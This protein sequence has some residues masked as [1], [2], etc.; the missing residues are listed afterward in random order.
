MVS[1]PLP[2]GIDDFEKVICG[3]YYYVD[4][5]NF[6]KELLDMKGEVNLFTRPR[7]FGKTLGISTV[8]YFF[9]DTGSSVENKKRQAL[10]DGMQIMQHGDRYTQE[11]NRYPVITLALKSS[12]QP[13]WDLAYGCLKEEIGREYLRHSE[14]LDH[15][16]TDE[17]Q[18]RFNDIMNLRGSQ[19]DFVTSIRFLSDCLYQYYKKK[20]IILIDEYD[21]PLENAYFSGFYAEMIDFLRSIFESSLKTNPSL[22]FAVLTGCLRISKESIFTGLNNPKMISILSEAYGEHFGFL[23]SEVDDMLDFYQLSEAK[24]LVKEWYDGYQ[25]GD[26][27]VYNPWS[28]INYVD[29]AMICKN[30]LPTPYWNNTS[31]NSIVRDLV[32]RAESK[33][34]SEIEQLIAGNTIEIPVHEDI[35]YADIH[36]SEDSIWNFL[37]FTGYLKKISL[38]LIGDIR[39]V[40]LAIP[41][42]EVRYIYNNTIL[43]WF[44]DKIRVEDLSGLYES[45]MAGEAEKFQKY[46]SSLLMKSIS[47]MDGRE[48]FY[49]GFLLGILE[50]M[51]EY[52]VTSNRE[53]GMG[54]YDIAVRHLDV[55]KAPVILELKVSDTY[56][57]MEAAC[58]AALKQIDSKHYDD[59]LPEEGYSEVLNYGISFFK[60][61]CRVKV[62]RKAFNP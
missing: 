22:E 2:I 28:V 57:G 56:K 4:K 40:K 38:R 3:G 21:V 60:K 25:F 10:F 16:K 46:L 42:R 47:Y 50:N 34:K 37:F 13:N 9:E 7:R 45:L 61:Q 5:T 49:H 15:L 58:D 20:V 44:R 12:K 59:W 48:E 26:S 19:Q 62:K 53:G 52:L 6:I 1:K 27:E 31:S 24:S 18:R 36:D 51:K 41:N 33:T 32:E 39:Y 43:N 17:Q 54:R 8:R 11:M 14:I 29:S 35:T 55:V 23:Q 30:V